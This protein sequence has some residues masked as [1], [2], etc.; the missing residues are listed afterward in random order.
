MYNW[1]FIKT[2]INNK[3]LNFT[4]SVETQY[5]YDKN[6]IKVLKKF[7][8]YE[9]YIKVVLFKLKYI[10]NI[11]NKI[12]SNDYNCD[13]ILLLRNKYPYNIE[14][15]I[16]HYVLF[17]LKPLNKSEI[18]K[19]LSKLLI[20]YEYIF[21]CNDKKRQSIKNLWHCQVFIKID[22]LKK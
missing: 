17:S 18:I 10:I 7:N 13:K 11:Q 8:T 20:N 2:K 9:D 16:K 19:I 15:G 14:K 4:R 6:K 22:S 5:N 21:F 3:N 1:S 12:E